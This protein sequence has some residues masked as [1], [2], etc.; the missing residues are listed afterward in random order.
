MNEHSSSVS[1]FACLF[2]K[3]TASVYP[4]LMVLNLSIDIS[5]FFELFFPFI[6]NLFLR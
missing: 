5:R 6:V 1:F 2:F 4:F 3:I